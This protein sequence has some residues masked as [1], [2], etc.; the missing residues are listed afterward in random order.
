MR[1]VNPLKGEQR[2]VSYRLGLKV[3]QSIKTYMETLTP[4][5]Q[6]QK[7]SKNSE[8]VSKYTVKFDKRSLRI[9]D[10]DLMDIRTKHAIEYAIRTNLSSMAPRNRTFV[11][12]HWNGIIYISIKK[13]VKIGDYRIPWHRD[14]HYMQAQGVRHKGFCV[15]AVY[16]NKPENT[17]GGEIQFARNGMRF[18]FVP[19]SGTS[20]TFFDD[21][22]F[23]R[24]IPVQAPPGLEYVPRSAFFFAFFTN[25]NGPF[26]M[27]ITETNV[28]NR[29]YEKF[30]KTIN[31]RSKQILNKNMINFTNQ[32]KSNMNQAA[33]GFFKRDDATYKNV[34]ALYNN[35]KRTFV[36]KTTNQNSRFVALVKPKTV[37]RRR[38][39]IPLSTLMSALGIRATSPMNINTNPRTRALS[40]SSLRR[41]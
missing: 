17:T 36:N 32:N 13:L 28:P 5:E 35:M 7:N 19:P 34:K 25:E 11:T 12:K 14:S 39:K 33:R 30:F 20:V 41:V 2:F 38:K 23:H 1:N 18:G 21:E 26:K 9:E 27:G 24:V 3:P 10:G 29:N 22:I 16:V 31:A 6:A 40:R 8:V 15:G 4:M 37:Y